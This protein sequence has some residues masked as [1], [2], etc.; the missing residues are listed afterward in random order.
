MSFARTAHNWEVDVFTLLFQVLYI[1]KVR[2]ECE[3]KLWWVP[4]KKGSV[5]IKSFTVSGL[6]VKVF[7]SPGECLAD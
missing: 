7:A 4:S 1:G 2:W 5:G 6:E 3:D